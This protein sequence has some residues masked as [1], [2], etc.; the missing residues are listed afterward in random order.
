MPFP[1][2]VFVNRQE[3]LGWTSL[4]LSRQKKELTGSLEVE[5]FQSYQAGDGMVAP[6]IIAGAEVLVYVG[7]YLAFTGSVDRRAD[8]GSLEQA[9]LNVNA[10]ASNYSVNFSC[11][12][13]AKSLI[14]NAHQHPTGTI[15]ETDN[16]SV[17]EFL[18]SP[19]GISI[20]WQAE[21]VSLNRKRFRNGSF[22]I[23]ELRRLAA[24]TSIYFY[25]GRD[26]L[27][28][29][30]DGPEAATGV[31]LILGRNILSFSSLQ[32]N[33]LSRQTVEIRG[34]RTLKE[35]WGAKAVIPPVKQLK[36]LNSTNSNRIVVRM[37]GDAN[38]E[39]LQRRGTYEQNR[40]SEESKQIELS[41]FHVQQPNGEP[42]DLGVQHQVEIPPAG[43]S[44]TFE[45]T[46]LTYNVQNDRTLE[47]RL[48]LS[49]PPAKVTAAT[50]FMAGAGAGLGGGQGVWGSPDL[51]A[52]S[53]PP[54]AQPT[55]P[56]GGLFDASDDIDP[57][58]FYNPPPGRINSAVDL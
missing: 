2:S 12:G 8:N 58:D 42:W 21:S 9:N 48:T 13:K 45:V 20:D 57:N 50:A 41:V 4:S 54:A 5:L 37:F 6:A 22:V 52:L 38:D 25:E 29:V 24:Q 15:L 31:P 3:L 27:L 34:Q 23:D 35:E 44:G 18:V 56:S 30:L 17:F 51:D 14:D 36:E 53:S 11:R 46:A 28:K 26:G 19:F 10:T 47:T 1:V 43:I 40:R 39:A 32:A 16:R 55:G 7:G 49:P 33:D